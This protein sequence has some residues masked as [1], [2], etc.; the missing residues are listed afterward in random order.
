[1]VES[2]GFWNRCGPLSEQTCYS[3]NPD[4]FCADVLK[5]N[6]WPEMFVIQNPSQDRKED[7]RYTPSSPENNAALQVRKK[8]AISDIPDQ[9]A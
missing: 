6:C 8:P 7:V 4:K 9:S 5:V 1:M 3:N 2:A